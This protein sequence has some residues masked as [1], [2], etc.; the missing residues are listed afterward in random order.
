[1]KIKWYYIT[2]LIALI[3]LLLF[4]IDLGLTDTGSCCTPEDVF[5][6]NFYVPFLMLGFIIFCMI[7]LGASLE[8]GVKRTKNLSDR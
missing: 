1:M 5:I 6:P 8:S 3:C 4:F 2:S 7:S